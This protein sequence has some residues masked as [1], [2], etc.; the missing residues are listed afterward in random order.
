MKL[1]DLGSVNVIVGGNNVGKTSVLEAIALMSDS[2][3]YNL[4]QVAKERDKHRLNTQ[5]ELSLLVLL[6]LDRARIKLAR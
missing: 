4:T 1:D 5:T 2:S 6:K 3:P